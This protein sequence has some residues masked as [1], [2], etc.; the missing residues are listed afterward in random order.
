MFSGYLG[1][2]EFVPWSSIHLGRYSFWGCSCYLGVYSDVQGRIIL[3]ISNQGYN[4][5]QRKLTEAANEPLPWLNLDTGEYVR[6]IEKYIKFCY[7]I[8]SITMYKD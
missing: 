5:V 2:T 8:H 7:I 6:P 3:S 1:A 4:E